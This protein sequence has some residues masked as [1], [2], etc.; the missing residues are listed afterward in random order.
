MTI[1][2]KYDDSTG[3]ITNRYYDSAPNSEWTET[4]EGDWP[5]DNSGDNEVPRYFY[6]DATGEITVE[7]KTIEDPDSTA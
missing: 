3:R 7:Y 5:K 4:L 6:D 2:I 1:A